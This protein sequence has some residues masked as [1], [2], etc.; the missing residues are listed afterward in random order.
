M[1]GREVTSTSRI[2]VINTGGTISCVGTPLSPMAQ[3]F[4]RALLDNG[5][6]SALP[7]IAQQFH[8]LIN[9]QSGVS[10][11]LVES[12]FPI[13][14]AQLADVVLALGPVLR[15]RLAE[16]GQVAHWEQVE[17]PLADVLARMELAGI[18][19]DRDDLARMGEEFHARKAEIERRIYAL[20]EE[21]G[22]TA[23]LVSDE[24][25]AHEDERYWLSSTD[26]IIV[27]KNQALLGAPA[28][29]QGAVAIGGRENFPIFT[30][31]Y[32]NLLRILK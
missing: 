7:E 11:A 29:K 27:T 31:D 8:A 5:R 4:L 9:A 28:I 18:R 24:P 1:E 13:D 19:V 30:D 2:A 32:T 10:D 3:N 20:A 17:R 12:A 21:H 25:P 15:K 22:M 23:V 6:L 14:G 26:Q 16:A